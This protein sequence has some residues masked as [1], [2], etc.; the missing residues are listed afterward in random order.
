MNT[1]SDEDGFRRFTLAEA[2]ALL[3][4]IIR[5]TEATLEELQRLHARQKREEADDPQKAQERFNT[6]T[7]EILERWSRQIASMGVYPKGFFTCDFKTYN[8][9]TLFCWTYGEERITH[10]HKVYEN[11]KQ[12]RPIREPHLDGFEFSLN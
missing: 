9:D 2:N 11:F 5:I 3:P 10:T 4:E 8:P 1:Y 6:H 7:M 12:R